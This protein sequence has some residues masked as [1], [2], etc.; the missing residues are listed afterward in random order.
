MS[1]PIF[2]E[3]LDTIAPD[4]INMSGALLRI[5]GNDPWKDFFQNN[6]MLKQQLLNNIFCRKLMLIA[7]NLA[8]DIIF[9]YIIYR[10]TIISKKP[11]LKSCSFLQPNKLRFFNVKIEGGHYEKQ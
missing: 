4:G 10:R 5:V 3:E 1:I 11:K 2:W 7:R 8:N 6:Q 9:M